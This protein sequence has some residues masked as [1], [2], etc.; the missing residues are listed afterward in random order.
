[1]RDVECFEW[2]LVDGLLSARNRDGGVINYKSKSESLHAMHEYVGG[3]WFVFE[4][5]DF[6]KR[7]V[8][9]YT[10]DRKASFRK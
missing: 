5:V 2:E 1:M 3:C 10:P 4:G 8:D 9:E 6:S 7:I